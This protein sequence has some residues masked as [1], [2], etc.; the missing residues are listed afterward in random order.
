MKNHAYKPKELK[1]IKD[2]IMRNRF[3]DI[4]SV[5]AT[6]YN[7]IFEDKNKIIRIQMNIRENMKKYDIAP[8]QE[9]GCDAF[10]YIDRETNEI[11]FLSNKV[12]MDNCEEHSFWKLGYKGKS[13]Q[14]SIKKFKELATKNIFDVVDNYTLNY[15]VLPV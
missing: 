10:G 11:L 4:K 14:L 7:Y 13:K 2:D 5:K 9:N 1:K 15:G 3:P 8:S 6:G 12:Y